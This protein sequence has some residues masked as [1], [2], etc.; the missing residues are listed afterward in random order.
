MWMTRVEQDGAVIELYKHGITRRHINL[1]HDGGAYQ[2][3]GLGYD[4]VALDI[5]IGRVF[6]GLEDMGWTRETDYNDELVAAKYK[7]LRDAGW[8]VIT[9]EPTS[10]F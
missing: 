3:N 5:A 2:Y 4:P 10:W 8:T 9:T 7:A 1:D 6:D